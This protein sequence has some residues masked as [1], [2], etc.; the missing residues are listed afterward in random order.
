MRVSDA[1]VFVNGPGRKLYKL[2]YS[3][4]DEN[5]KAID[6]TVLAEHITAV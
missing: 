4:I 3:G 5:Y 2:D 6:L 1:I